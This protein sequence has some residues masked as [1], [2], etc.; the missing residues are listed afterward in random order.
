MS[1]EPIFVDS[2]EMVIFWTWIF[3]N[4]SEKK[5]NDK[6]NHYLDGTHFIITNLGYG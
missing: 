6:N 4:Y 5:S 2:A 1:E 3:Y